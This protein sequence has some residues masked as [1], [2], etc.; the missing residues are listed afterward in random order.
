MSHPFYARLEE[1]P[2][3]NKIGKIDKSSIEYQM[4]VADH[5]KMK[6]YLEYDSRVQDY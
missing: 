2:Y 1:H 5:P 3:S 6:K 4:F